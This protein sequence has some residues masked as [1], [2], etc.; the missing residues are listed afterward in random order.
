METRVGKITHFYNH[1]SVAVLELSRELKV[2]DNIHIL[3]HSTDFDQQVSS[4]EIEHQKVLSAGPRMEVALK[5]VGAVRRS[6]KVFRVVGD[7]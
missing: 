3:G 2:G 6:D 4:M 7:Q 5:V 1:L